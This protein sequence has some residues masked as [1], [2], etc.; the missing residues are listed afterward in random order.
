MKE[1]VVGETTGTVDTTTWDHKPATK[2][3]NT[4]EPEKE[5]L[6]EIQLDGSP[7]LRKVER[8]LNISPSTPIGLQKKQQA[9]D[10]TKHPSHNVR[11]G[12]GDVG[13]RA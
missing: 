3:T 7:V 12:C 1:N 2:Q 8:P 10:N 9:R 13:P 4:N 5:Q 6:V 11:P